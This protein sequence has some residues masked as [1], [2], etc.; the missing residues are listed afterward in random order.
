MEMASKC[1]GLVAHFG[2][3]IATLLL[4]FMCFEHNGVCPPIFNWA[5]VGGCECEF[6]SD[7]C[8]YVH[9]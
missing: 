9:V 4:R 6:V 8:L 5:Q 2:S 7:I 3:G 1:G